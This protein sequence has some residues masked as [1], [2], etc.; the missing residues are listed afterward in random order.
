MHQFEI[1]TNDLPVG[2]EVARVEL[3]LSDWLIQID[4]DDDGSYH[5]PLASKGLWLLPGRRPCIRTRPTAPAEAG[6]LVRMARSSLIRVSK[7]A[8]DSQC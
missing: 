2:I 7:D 8:V 1:A 3:L 5:V 4:R 6:G